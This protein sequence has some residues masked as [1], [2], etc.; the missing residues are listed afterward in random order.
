MNQIGPLFV[1][2]LAG[3]IGL[4]ALAVAVSRNA[5]T[6]NIISGAGSALSSVISAAVAPVVASG[7]NNFG[8]SSSLGSFT[9][10]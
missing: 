10:A 2:V 4:A 1:T 6:S 9:S 5:Q 8:A 3:I 7:T